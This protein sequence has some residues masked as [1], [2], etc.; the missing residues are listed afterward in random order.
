MFA[1]RFPFSSYYLGLDYLWMY[2]FERIISFLS[3]IL[4]SPMLEKQ[5]KMKVSARER[6]EELYFCKEDSQ[7]TKESISIRIASL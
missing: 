4:E 6:S 3:L 5:N 2:L 1:L 7:L